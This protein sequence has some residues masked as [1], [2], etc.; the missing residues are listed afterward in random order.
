[1]LGR[2]QRAQTR[3]P[4]AW[5]GVPPVSARRRR[6]CGSP[7]S[8]VHPAHAHLSR[9]ATAKDG[10]VRRDRRRSY[11]ACAESLDETWRTVSPIGR[12]R[13][14]AW[15]HGGLRFARAPREINLGTVVRRTEPDLAIAFCFGAGPSCRINGVCGVA[16]V[17]ADALDGVPGGAG[18]GT[19]ADL[20]AKR[21]DPLMRCS[22]SALPAQPVA[23][24]CRSRDRLRELRSLRFVARAERA[25]RCGRR[26]RSAPC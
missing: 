26:A 1:M 20:V 4:A 8:R 23:L 14:P 9:P 11:G 18:R 2:S 25:R 6:K 10:H 15:H 21:R 12:R 17:L 22:E 13:H 19:L 3:N 24:H 5:R 7:P 16:D